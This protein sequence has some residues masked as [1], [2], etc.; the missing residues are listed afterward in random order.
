MS[1][2]LEA[3]E[4]TVR[5][6]SADGE[7]FA[8]SDISLTLNAGETVGLVG[9]SGCG[10]STLGKALMRLIPA[11][12]E[13]HLDGR[14]ISELSGKQL[15]PFRRQVQM[16]FQDPQGSLN[17]RQPVGTSI[18]R[19][20]QVAGWKRVAIEQ[21][22]AQLLDQVGLPASAAQRYPH[23]FSGG[24]RQRIGIAR[25]LALEPQVVICDEPVSALDVSVRAQVINLMRDIQQRMGV[26]YLFI[27]HDLSVVEYL[28]HRVLVMY[29]GRIV[30]SGPTADIWRQ[31]AHPYTRAL[32]AAAP[33][34]D[35][36]Q[37]RMQPLLQGELPSPL[38]PPDGCAFHT[39][40]PH[41]QAI[42]RQQRPPL[43]PLTSE[44][45]VA[46][47]FHLS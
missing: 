15:L 29:L 33:V 17:P 35:P 42:C 5:Y 8:L 20:L 46:C 27:S 7:V 43:T 41:A 18:A 26:A 30:E 32:L 28:A 9:E 47:H 23:E 14:N 44:R 21:R 36:R 37:P 34:A 31:P 6:P 40:C 11:A 22:V 39:R 4:L 25:A 10:K 2:L 16:M 3:R 12:G 13:I 38:S 45:Q 19:P 1:R 24:Q